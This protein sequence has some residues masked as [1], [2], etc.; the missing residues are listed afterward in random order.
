LGYQ[1]ARFHLLNYCRGEKIQFSNV[2]KEGEVIRPILVNRAMENRLGFRIGEV[3]NF[4]L[5]DSSRSARRQIQL[6]H[7][8]D[9]DL[10]TFYWTDGSSRLS[11]YRQANVL[12]FYD[13]VGEKHSPLWDF[14]LAA[15][16]V[17]TTYGE[18]LK[19]KDCF[20]VRVSDRRLQSL[21][22]IFCHLIWNARLHSDAEYELDPNQLEIRG[23]ARLLG[24]TQETFFK[25]DPIL[26]FTEFRVGGRVYQRVR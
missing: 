26:G 24:H 11:Y 22:R 16:R 13:L 14:F 25:M 18:K 2:P 21:L 17:P 6:S 23:K 3:L 15:P 1:T 20:S 4:E 7:L 12:V 8:L 5:Q 10:G 9:P 19:F